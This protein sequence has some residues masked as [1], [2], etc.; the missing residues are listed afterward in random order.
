MKQETHIIPM[1]ATYCNYD[2]NEITLVIAFHNDSGLATDHCI[3]PYPYCA[4]ITEA[5][6]VL[7]IRPTADRTMRD[8]TL[9]Q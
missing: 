8:A 5:S 6:L 9:I 2:H 4:S 3:K 7:N 1:T